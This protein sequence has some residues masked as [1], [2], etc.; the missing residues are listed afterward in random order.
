VSG[1]SPWPIVLVPP[2][3]LYNSPRLKS[4][5][6]VLLSISYWSS[7]SGA[8]YQSR[9]LYHHSFKG[10][11]LGIYIE[12]GKATRYSCFISGI[13]SRCPPHFT[14]NVPSTFSDVWAPTHSYTHLENKSPT[15]SLG[16]DRPSPLFLLHGKRRTRQQQQLQ[17]VLLIQTLDYKPPQLLIPF[18]CVPNIYFLARITIFT[19]PPMN[20]PFPAR[21]FPNQ[22]TRTT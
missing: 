9:S 17:L 15:H 4:R 5:V 3:S 21:S 11:H 16:L 12:G 14:H 18:I 20:E 1:V 10:T 6:P 13:S 22:W 19:F 7:P 8:V 2:S